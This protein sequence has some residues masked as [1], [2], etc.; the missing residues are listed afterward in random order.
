[1]NNFNVLDLNLDKN[2]TES[3]VEQ[4]FIYPFLTNCKPNTLSI[5]SSQILTKLSLSKIKI[6]KGLASKTYFPDYIITSNGYPIVVIEAKKPSD[7]D[8]DEAYRE[9]RLYAH[10]INIKY[11]QEINPLK[12]I[13]ATNGTVFKFGLS[14]DNKYLVDCNVK[15][16]V[17]GSHEF[18]TLSSYINNDNLRRISL[19]I[20]SKINLKSKKYY[21]ARK[22]VGGKSIQ[23]E[24]VDKNPLGEVIYDN[25]NW[26]FNPVKDSERE[27]IV[28]NGY[29]GT[30]SNKKVYD[31]IDKVIKLANTASQ[32]IATEIKNTLSPIEIY[33]VLNKLSYDQII[34]LIG[35]VGVGKSTFIDYLQYTD[36]IPEKLRNKLVWIR[37]NLN[38]SPINRDSIYK[39]VQENI[40]QELQSKYKDSF[41]FE[42]LDFIKKL[43]SV[44]INKFNKGI[45]QLLIDTDEK[46]YNNKLF[47]LL[48]SCQNNLDL[49]TRCYIRHLISEREKSL[50]ITLDNCDKKDRDSQLLMFEV[51]SWAKECFRSIIILPLRDETYD[52]Y[53]DEKPLDTAI[54]EY[55]FRIDSPSFQKILVRR[56]QLA[57]NE[58]EKNMGTTK[59][60]I[61]LDNNMYVN[62]DPS[63]E[64][65]TYLLAMLN[66]VL[67]NQN[68]IRKILTGLSGGNIRVALE[69]FLGFCSSG[70]I[71]NEEIVKIRS[72]DGNYA[73]PIHIAVKALMRGNRKYYNSNYSN[74]KNLIDVDDKFSSIP[75]Y[76]CRLAILR[77]LKL[78]ST[79]TK[80]RYTGYLSIHEL[81]NNLGYFG[82]EVNSIKEQLQYL[83][84]SR[85]VITED[86]S[87]ETNDI[88]DSTLIK[89]APAG[90]AHIEL[91][92]NNIVYLATIAEDTKINDQDILDKITNI[93]ISDNASSLTRVYQ[94]AK[95]LLEYMENIETIMYQ[96]LNNYMDENKLKDI[97]LISLEDVKAM[98][99]RYSDN[100]VKDN[101]Y[102][103]ENWI[104][105]TRNNPINSIV[106]GTVTNIQTFGV[107]VKLDNSDHTGLI[108]KSKGN[109]KEFSLNQRIEKLRILDIDEEKQTISLGLPT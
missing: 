14:M 8:V 36:A 100:V 48:E 51:A 74:I 43:Y 76:F 66:S 35:R 30:D 44:E 19:E 21:R 13:I 103:R 10:A 6:D 67:R 58:I 97:N 56:V 88:S 29:I 59:K 26:I 109:I 3:D 105:F 89:I 55:S 32:N 63:C 86:F 40:I 12:Y 71:P 75:T 106:S 80:N 27:Y 62:F 87:I 2:S 18:D 68:S 37:L 93:I 107:F 38:N 65:S 102:N 42:G 69:M 22:S 5:S 57:L 82:F 92:E 98:I 28:K 1:M 25:Y 49:T 23:N 95:Y 33:S 50:I 46:E 31:E 108:H 104:D 52:N 4:K 81:I 41:D 83:I 77:Y 61:N 7:N 91:F 70:H 45:G 47:E 99:K 53:K 17:I 54:K 9:A 90:Y 15:D 78:N 73:M 84:K 11:S 79:N 16:L 96:K 64:S 72:F 24:E 39:W 94:L 60:Q 34:L 20:A 85:C 101:R